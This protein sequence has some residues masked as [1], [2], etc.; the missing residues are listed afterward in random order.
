[1]SGPL[2]GIRV[3]DLT[4][5]LLGPYCTRLLADLGAEVIKVEPPAG[6][7]T[8]RLGPARS[9]GMGGVHLNVNRGKR[10]VV[11]DLKEPGQ[12]DALLRLAAESDVF[13][14][15]IRPAAIERL[16]LGY[17]AVAEAAPGIV[18]CAATGYG[19]GGPRSGRP[20]YDDLV[21]AASGLADLNAAGGEPR[22]VP[23]VV[24]DKTTGLMAAVGILGALVRRGT[25]G[26]G[27]EV[28]VPMYE[29]M[30]SFLM[31]EHLYGHA[32]EP[33]LAPVGYPRATSPD[34]R[35]YATR[36]GHIALMPYTDA[37][38]AAFFAAAG[39]PDL[40]AD[41]RFTDLGART[42][43][44][45]ALYSAAAE[46]V[47]ERT[48]GEWMALMEAADVPVARVAAAGDLVGDAH[49]DAVGL[50]TEEEHPTEGSVRT[51][52]APIRYP[53]LPEHRPGPAERL[54][55]SSAELLGGLLA[56]A[57]EGGTSSA[58]AGPAPERG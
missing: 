37:H 31:V 19:A 41:P 12:R 42:A 35:P 49:A 33:P 9:P 46:L 50:F 20:A 7:P 29:T 1:M 34:R 6:D 23:S 2:D 8:R 52:R 57:E 4:T 26:Q 47:A 45:D 48:T 10:S 17:A 43:H 22:Y 14:H 5:V 36:D 56:E 32:F 54:G 3:L 18:Y 11:C 58:A 55:Q 24:A 40:A 51:V 53:G 21:Q 30:A 28:E 16:G 15:N 44:I 13:V 39:R 27:C 25:T 38:W